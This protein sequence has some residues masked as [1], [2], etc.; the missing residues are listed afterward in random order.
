M[1]FLMHYERWS[2]KI[3]SITEFSD[4]ESETAE[5]ARLELEIVLHSSAGQSEVVVLEAS[6]IN[7][8]RQ[9]HSRYFRTLG[10]LSETSTIDSSVNL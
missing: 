9:T 4:S 3:V 1:I 5:K 6:D 8:L 2:G 7:A 10:E